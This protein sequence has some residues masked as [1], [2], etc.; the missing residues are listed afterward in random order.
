MTGLSTYFRGSNTGDF[1]DI[2]ENANACDSKNN[3][4]YIRP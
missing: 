1:L 3:A 4:N 2:L